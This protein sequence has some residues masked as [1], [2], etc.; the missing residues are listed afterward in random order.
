MIRDVH[1][2]LMFLSVLCSHNMVVSDLYM[3]KKLLTIQRLFYSSD[4]CRKQDM[5]LHRTF[6]MT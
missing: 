3:A 6:R 4:H 5:K 1:G 2:V